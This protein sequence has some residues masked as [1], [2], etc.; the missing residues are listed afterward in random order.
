MVREPPVRTRR[1]RLSE[2]IAIAYADQ[3]ILERAREN[4]RKANTDGLIQVGDA[5]VMFRGRTGRS[6]QAGQLPGSAAP[7]SAARSRAA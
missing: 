7:R 6:S 2:L 3:D 1:A 5:V 4:L